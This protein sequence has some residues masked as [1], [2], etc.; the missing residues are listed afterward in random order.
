MGDL[1]QRE[2]SLPPDFGNVTTTRGTP[3]QAPFQD[4]FF[5]HPG[6]PAHT[7][8]ASAP[9][10]PRGHSRSI[11]RDAAPEPRLLSSQRRESKSA[12][13]RTAQLEDENRRLTERLRFLEGKMEENQAIQAQ[14]RQSRVPPPSRDNNA[15]LRQVL[16]DF[17]RIQTDM[18]RSQRQLLE[19]QT[20]QTHDIPKFTGN[21][22]PSY[23]DWLDRVISIKEARG[24]DEFRMYR[25]IKLAL[26]DPAFSTVQNDPENANTYQGLLRV[27]RN[28]F[29]IRNP[30]THY[31]D[32]L[33]S[34]RQLE[35][36]TGQAY[37]GRF[38]KLHRRLN[39][40][41]PG[42]SLY[43]E[44]TLRAWFKRGLRRAHKTLLE[45]KLKFFGAE[46]VS[47][48]DC[49]MLIKTSDSLAK[50]MDR[51]VV[52]SANAVTPTVGQG[53]RAQNVREGPQ[54]KAKIPQECW[55]CGIPNSHHRDQ[56]NN[57]DFKYCSYCHF[58]NSHI[59]RDC[60]KKKQDNEA[61]ST[62]SRGKGRSQ[63]KGTRQSKGRQGKY[64]ANM[65]ASAAVTQLEP[66]HGNLSPPTPSGA[67]DSTFS[68]QKSH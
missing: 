40:A 17:V 29:G 63:G 3:P 13:F 45:T 21:S 28:H 14:E 26:Y 22:A 64:K 7:P 11:S 57:G 66:S 52:L 67:G 5:S 24:W 42:D 38:T 44:N 33:S 49:L 16:T 39:D 12:E 43:D 60:Y 1:P 19:G 65:S 31:V 36:E 58:I 41:M 6:S 9:G 51:P 18:A 35:D 47:L 54:S 46:N 27:L 2:S 30:R 34:I 37:V 8:S 10:L 25:E 56:C 50:Q 23:E 15:D 59:S 48:A 61:A 55:R 68:E 32:K 4:S 53:Q 62:G 20:A